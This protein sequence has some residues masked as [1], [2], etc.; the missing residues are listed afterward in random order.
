MRAEVLE[1]IYSKNELKQFIREQP[2]WYRRLS[3]HP[4]DLE[5]FEIA[6][7]NYYERTIPHRVDKFYNNLQMASMMMSM[8]QN[9]NF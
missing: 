9:I 4:E 6:S 7:L 2:A 3:R 1:Y 8:L 5:Q